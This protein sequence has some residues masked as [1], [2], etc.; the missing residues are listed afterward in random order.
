MEIICQHAYLLMHAWVSPLYSL[1]CHSELPT[2]TKSGTQSPFL[3]KDI[4]F[5]DWE[6][7]PSY[8]ICNCILLTSCG[9]NTETSK[10][11]FPYGNSCL[12]LSISQSL[13]LLSPTTPPWP[14][15][16]FLT[17]TTLTFHAFSLP[18]PVDLWQRQGT[19][20]TA[21]SLETPCAVCQQG[22]KPSHLYPVYYEVCT[23]PSHQFHQAR[24]T[25]HTCAPP[26][27]SV[28][29]GR[30]LKLCKVARQIDNN[31]N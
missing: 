6:G 22:I 30:K 23:I 19:A 4:S 10:A 1:P 25:I 28:T 17:P 18:L 14:K 15:T 11:C 2:L 26:S 20:G 5:L 16:P 12:L 13:A 9:E 3:L 8:G 21:G 27:S 24:R 29:T 7:K 31:D